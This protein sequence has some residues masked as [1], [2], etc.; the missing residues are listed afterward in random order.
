MRVLFCITLFALLGACAGPQPMPAA[1]AGDGVVTIIMVRHA[2]TNQAVKHLPLSAVGEQRAKLLTQT[3]RGVKPTHLFASHTVRAK[4]MLD[5]T[6]AARG[7]RVTQLPA[8]GST[9]GGEVVTDQTNRQA[10]VEPIG[11]ALRKL[12]PGSVAIVALNSENIYGILNRVGV[13][14]VADCSP[15]AMCVPCTNNTCFPR[16]SF[17]LVWHVVLQPGAER[18]LSMTELR[19]GQGWAPAKP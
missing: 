19:Y 6:A 8:P 5:E 14:V 2:E 9:V 7:L 10:A 13:P 3:L 11:E 1:R 16:D 17:D 18:P 4:Q 15:G 12:P